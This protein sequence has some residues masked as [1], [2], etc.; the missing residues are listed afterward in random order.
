MFYIFL[1][2]LWN[3]YSMTY[4]D[5][6]KYYYLCCPCLEWLLTD[7]VGDP[8]GY[9][10]F[11]W[12]FSNKGQYWQTSIQLRLEWCSTY[13]YFQNQFISCQ[14]LLR[15]KSYIFKTIFVSHNIILDSGEH[16]WR[17]RTQFFILEPVL[18]HKTKIMIVRAWSASTWS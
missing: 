2:S 1:Q 16:Y 18:K 3:T 13:L 15:T 6:C 9:D 17:S 12:K 11:C 5:T 7:F 10:L 14:R 8:F 4:R